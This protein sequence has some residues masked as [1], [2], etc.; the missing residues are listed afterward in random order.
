MRLEPVCDMRLSY[1]GGFSLVKPYGGDRRRR[2]TRQIELVKGTA[3]WRRARC[4]CRVSA[5]ASSP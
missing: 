2:S 3:P 5:P 4:Q 1:Q